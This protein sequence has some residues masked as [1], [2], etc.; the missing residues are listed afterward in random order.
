MNLL[1]KWKTKIEEL[2]DYLKKLLIIY[3]PYSGK[4]KDMKVL[5]EELESVSES[6][7]Y[8]VKFIKTKAKN[9]ATNIVENLHKRYELVLSLGGD[10]NRSFAS[11]NY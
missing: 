10:G 8:K 3:N 11:R 1:M 5:K 2:G 6:Y 9:D 4:K 7:G